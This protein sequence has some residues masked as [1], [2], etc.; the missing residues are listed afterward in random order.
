FR[1]F[2]PVLRDLAVVGQPGGHAHDAPDLLAVGVRGVVDQRTVQRLV[3]AVLGVDVAGV[4]GARIAVVAVVVRGVA[5]NHAGAGEAAAREARR[6]APGPI[7]QRLLRSAPAV[8][9]TLVAAVSIVRVGVVG[10][11]HFLAMETG[12]PPAVPGDLLRRRA[13]R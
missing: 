5:W 6:L 1:A 9:R 13:V 4:L 11:R 3:D 12:H 8:T 7:R 2:E 10:R